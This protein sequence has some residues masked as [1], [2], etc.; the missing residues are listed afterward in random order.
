MK[1]KAQSIGTLI[2]DFL[3]GTEAEATLLERKIP[4]LWTE[5]LDRKSVV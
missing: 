3:R 1:H 4:Q 5:V 2:A